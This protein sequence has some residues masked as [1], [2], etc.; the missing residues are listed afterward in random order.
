MLVVVWAYDKTR[1]VWAFPVESPDGATTVSCLQVVM[2]ELRTLT[3]G[4][5]PPVLRAHSDRAAAFLGKDVKQFLQAH[6]VRQT[7]NSGHDPKA[8]GLAER[9][10]GLIK[11]R[12]TSTLIHTKLGPDFW[13]FACQYVAM[14]HNARVL[15]TPRMNSPIFGEAVVY[16]KPVDKPEAFTGRGEIGVFLGWHHNISHGAYVM[17]DVDGEWDTITTAKIREIKTK[18]VWRLSRHDEDPTKSV[19]VNQKGEVTWAPPMDQLNTVEEFEFK[20]LY[21]E[22]NLKKMSPEWAWWYQPLSEV[23]PEAESIRLAKSERDHSY[24][25]DN[26]EILECIGEREKERRT[27][28]IDVMFPVV[29]SGKDRKTLT[30]SR[31]QETGASGLRAGVPVEAKSDLDLDQ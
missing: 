25:E 13:P 14:C 29:P 23:M 21:V 11:A 8:N 31:I 10:V 1:L 17:I 5:R 15:N 27:D 9:W 19:Y 12:T 24:G 3:G 22:Y 16:S 6:D 26:L 2:E 7:T 18:D 30:V 20:G 28:P 4:S